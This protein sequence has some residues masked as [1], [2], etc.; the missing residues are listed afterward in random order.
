MSAFVFVGINLMAYALKES[1]NVASQ[2]IA[3]FL[4]RVM[5]QVNRVKPVEK[6]L[7]GQGEKRG[8]CVARILS[9]PFETDRFTPVYQVKLV[10]V[11]R[12]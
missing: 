12:Q 3:D 2:Q 6:P 9:N 7:P 1:A 10:V 11:C 4:D 8:S 5:R